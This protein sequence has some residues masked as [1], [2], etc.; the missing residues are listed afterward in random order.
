M[1]A[2]NEDVPAFNC[3]TIRKLGRHVGVTS[4]RSSVLKVYLF[5]VMKLVCKW[6][7]QSK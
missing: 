2:C 3:P 4:S 7:E 6:A 1:Y 5:S